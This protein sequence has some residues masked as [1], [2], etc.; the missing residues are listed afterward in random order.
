M[1]TRKGIHLHDIT[2]EIESVV[3]LGVVDGYVNVLSRH[4]TTAVCIN[5]AEAGCSTTSGSTSRLAPADHPYLPTTSTSAAAP[6]WPAATRRGGRRPR[7]R[8]APPQMPSGT[9]DGSRGERRA[10]DRH[11]ASVVAEL[12]GPRRRTVGVQAVGV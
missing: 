12:D 3:V 8:T 2:S 4:T 7:T 1:E 10:D 11:M 6:G 5:E 9:G